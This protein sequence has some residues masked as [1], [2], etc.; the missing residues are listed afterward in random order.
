[1]MD[2]R[3]TN[4]INQLRHNNNIHKR[5]IGIKYR[6]EDTPLRQG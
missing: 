4:I 1:M 3:N 2:P 5:P 6:V